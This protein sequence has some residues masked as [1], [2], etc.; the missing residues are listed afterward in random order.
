MFRRNPGRFTETIAL[1]RPS[2]P[3]RDALGGVSAITYTEFLK[4]RA[5]VT[6]KS[7]SKQQIIGD[8]VTVDTRY[9]L[10]RDTRKT[11]PDLDSTWRLE[12]GGKAYKINDVLL[13]DESR[14][15]YVQ[16]TAT[17]ITGGGKL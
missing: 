3:K 5:L 7:Q 11:C 1:M 17:A 13:I 16:I 15:A 4:M 12:W 10:V 9:F 14:P 8:Y 2:A 6:V